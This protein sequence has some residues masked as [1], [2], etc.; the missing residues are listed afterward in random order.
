MHIINILQDMQ[1]LKIKKINGHSKIKYNGKKSFAYMFINGL[2][3]LSNLQSCR[4][5]V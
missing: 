2:E 3:V 5:I 4:P 1:H